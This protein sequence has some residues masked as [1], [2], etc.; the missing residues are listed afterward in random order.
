[1]TTI[2]VD[3]KPV[4]LYTISDVARA[5]GLTPH[6][7]WVR[8]KKAG[9]FPPPNVRHGERYYYSEPDFLALTAPA[10]AAHS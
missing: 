3:R 1:M 10:E 8:V 9:T 6:T 4:K 2:C 5:L 7:L